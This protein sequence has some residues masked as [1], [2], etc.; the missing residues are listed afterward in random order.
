[1]TC[2]ARAGKCVDFG[3]SVAAGVPALSIALRP[4]APNPTP[5]RAS[6]SRLDIRVIAPPNTTAPSRSRLC[7]AGR[8][9]AFF[10][11]VDEQQFV[12]AHQRLG[13]RWPRTARRRQITD[14]AIRLGLAGL[15]LK[16]DAIRL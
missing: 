10:H 6:I 13:V 5:V 9:A 15:A 11:L 1:M 2:L 16:Q 14:A 8:A 3:V 12:R 7:S 4:R